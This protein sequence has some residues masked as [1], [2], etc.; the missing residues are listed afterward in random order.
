MVLCLQSSRTQRR[1]SVPASHVRRVHGKQQRCS[2]RLGLGV[3]LGVLQA[4]FVGFLVRHLCALALGLLV[5]V[6]QLPQVVLH[7]EV[8]LHH[9]MPQ[10]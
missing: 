1:G 10:T 4:L 8:V 7:L 3:L 2:T 9:G 6:V 5:D